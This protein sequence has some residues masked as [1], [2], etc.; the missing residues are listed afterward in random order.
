M[1]NKGAM[2]ISV[3]FIDKTTEMSRSS[4]LFLTIISVVSQRHFK[5]FYTKNNRFKGK[6][7]VFYEEKPRLAI[8]SR[9]FFASQNMQSSRYQRL[10]KTVPFL[11]IFSAKYTL[12]LKIAREG[13]KNVSLFNIQ[14]FRRRGGLYARPKPHGSNSPSHL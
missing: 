2:I 9:Q 8:I 5:G 13:R 11:A 3:V 14:G 4:R 6:H 12:A 1:G 10:M 7:S